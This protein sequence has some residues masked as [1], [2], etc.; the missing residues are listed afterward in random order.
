MTYK[1][2]MISQQSWKIQLLRR[3]ESCE[4]WSSSMKPDDGPV[5]VHDDVRA[6]LPNLSQ[7]YND[8]LSG[9]R[10]IHADLATAC[11][12]VSEADKLISDAQVRSCT[13]L[14]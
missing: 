8:L 2:Q 5:S 12:R 3:E 7:R 11:E 10:D 14:L 13:W 9:V 1:S 6:Q 4:V